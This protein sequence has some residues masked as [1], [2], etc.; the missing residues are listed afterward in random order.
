MAA[1]VPTPVQLQVDQY[2]VRLFNARSIIVFAR[3]RVR[4]AQQAGEVLHSFN[5]QAAA[6]V[7]RVAHGNFAECKSLRLDFP[8]E[9]EPRVGRSL[10]QPEKPLQNESESKS[11]SENVNKSSV[12]DCLSTS[13]NTGRWNESQLVKLKDDPGGTVTI[14]YQFQD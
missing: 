4:C 6:S 9:C 10:P 1:L 13:K 3:K 5:R 8:F 2:G 12:L 11:N 7:G 14:S